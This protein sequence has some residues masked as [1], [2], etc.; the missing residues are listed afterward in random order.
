[1][2]VALGVLLLP[3]LMISWWFTRVPEPAPTRVDWAPIATAASASP[4]RIAV[5]Q[6]LPDTWT[7]VRARWTAKGDPG[8]DGKPVPGNT[9]QLGLLTPDRRYLGLDQRDER[10]EELL[11]E[12]TRD[13]RADGDSVVAGA[14][15]QRWIS[16]DA[17][18]RTLAITGDGS[19]L[20]LSGD[21]PYAELE[22]FAATLRR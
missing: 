11:A 22:A 3:I 15:W 17:R 14:R 7:C 18:T 10:P 5:P 2:I 6:A 4:Y 21:V 16:P 12:V 8:I 13:G 1:M 9:W 20:V 19:T